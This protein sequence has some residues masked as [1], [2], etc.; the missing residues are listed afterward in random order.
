MSYTL[1]KRTPSSCDGKGSEP[2]WID[3]VGTFNS[4]EEVIEELK[5]LQRNGYIEYSI[6]KGDELVERS[7]FL[8]L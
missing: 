3:E 5:N 1:I 6:Y 4:Y 8:E 7:H 2:D